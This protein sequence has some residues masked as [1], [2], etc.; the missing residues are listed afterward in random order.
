MSSD[1]ESI[2]SPDSKNKG[3][4]IVIDAEKMND[5]FFMDSDQEMENYGASTKASVALSGNI[6][7]QTNQEKVRACF[8]FY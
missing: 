3:G 2:Q 5:F 8:K 4:D 7:K 6:L 1:D